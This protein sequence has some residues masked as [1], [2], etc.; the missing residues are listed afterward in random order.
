MHLRIVL[1]LSGA[2]AILC[3]ASLSVHGSLIVDGKRAVDDW[4]RNAQAEQFVPE[5]ARN[6]VIPA[7]FSPVQAP[8]AFSLAASVSSTPRVPANQHP[9]NAPVLMYHYVRPITPDL[10]KMQKALTVT[11]EHFAAQMKAIM[12]LGYHT[13]TPDELYAAMDQG[14]A[15]PSKP[16]L[17]TFDDG[18]VG[19]YTY[20]FPILKQLGLKATFFVI[21][22]FH[23]AKSAYMDNAM[24][25]EMDRSG[26][27]TIAS[28]TRHHAW[29]VSYKTAVQQ[30]EIDGSKQD[31]EKLLGHTVTSFAYPYGK[32]DATTT[33][34]VRQAGYLTAFST[35]PGSE[36]TSSTLLELTRL[37]IF[38][39]EDMPVLLKRFSK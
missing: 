16:L 3:A 33:D 4:Q 27:C 6:V 13:I 30:D 9:I 32:F 38:D 10:T 18:Y 36:H 37:R 12:D 28:H 20:A 31:L 34:L 23:A 15:L 17:I 21:T 25:Q 29:L 7:D 19:Q 2:A 26:L 24:L 8:P 5:G 39:Y 35:K 22:D 14:A 11:P 1:P